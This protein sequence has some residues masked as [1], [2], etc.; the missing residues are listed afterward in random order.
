MV[1]FGLLV[2]TGFV[3]VID[4]ALT[5][6]PFPA[7]LA[8]WRVSAMWTVAIVIGIMASG[9]YSSRAGQPLFG[10]IDPA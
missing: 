9:S 6:V 8:G 4:A 5:G 2:A 1:R 10:K 3:F 7:K